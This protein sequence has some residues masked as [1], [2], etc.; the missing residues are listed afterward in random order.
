ML[1]CLTCPAR[2]RLEA[3]AGRG[4]TLAATHGPQYACL[5]MHTVSDWQAL[6]RQDSLDRYVEAEVHI[7]SPY[8]HLEAAHSGETHVFVSHQQH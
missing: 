8:I 1:I 2:L 4:A 6:L 5:K 3:Q 7:A